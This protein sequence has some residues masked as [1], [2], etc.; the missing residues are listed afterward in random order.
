MNAFET[1]PQPSMEQSKGLPTAWRWVRLGEVSEINP[2]RP[3]G[4]ERA[5]DAPTTFVPMSAVD[6]V[7]GVIAEPQ[8]RP[9]AKVAKGIR[10]SQRAMYSSRRLRLACKMENMRLRKG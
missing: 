8:V 1:M 5:D 6:A 2:R 7:N 4:L 9:Y 10:I 3:N